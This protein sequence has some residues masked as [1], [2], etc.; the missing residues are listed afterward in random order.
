LAG[1]FAGPLINCRGE[2]G[3]KNKPQGHFIPDP[4]KESEN[5]SS[6]FEPTGKVFLISF[7]GF[8]SIHEL[9]VQTKRKKERN[10]PLLRTTRMHSQL[11]RRVSLAAV[12]QKNKQ[13]K[14]NK[15]DARQSMICFYLPTSRPEGQIEFFSKR[16]CAFS[17]QWNPVYKAFHR[18]SCCENK[19]NCQ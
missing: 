18:I 2:A 9:G 14:T 11:L 16:M 5:R 15:E 8:K 13:T 1:T 7:R 17:M 12:L 19:T 6:R 10:S 4:R 3:T